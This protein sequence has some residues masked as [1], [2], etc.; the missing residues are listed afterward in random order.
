MIWFR[1]KL[2]EFCISKV[3]IF[4]HLNKGISLEM[5]KDLNIVI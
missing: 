3:T 5:V 4:Y 1:I 2:V